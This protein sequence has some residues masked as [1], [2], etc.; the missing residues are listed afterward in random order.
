MTVAGSWIDSL[1]H[2]FPESWKFDT[3]PTPVLVAVYRSFSPEVAASTVAE[4][5]HILGT[6][7]LVGSGKFEVPTS[8]IRP[9]DY[10]GGTPTFSIDNRP[11]TI[12]G[13]FCLILTPCPGGLEGEGEDVA[14]GLLSAAASIVRVCLGHNSAYDHLSTF[15]VSPSGDWTVTSPAVRTPSTLFSPEMHE[16]KAALNNV[17]ALLETLDPLTASRLRQSL[18]WLAKA[19]TEER[20]EDAFLSLW[21]AIECLVMKTSD[22]RDISETLARYYGRT[23]EETKDWLS[24]GKVYG[25]R[26][27]IAHKGWM[28][29]IESDVTDYLE[30]IY[31]DLLFAVVGLPGRRRCEQAVSDGRLAELLTSLLR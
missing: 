30:C 24:I 22:I 7:V 2:T 4:A 12:D 17:G 3:E 29:G 21:I 18:R 27:R 11:D 9:Q 5:F 8:R 10:R 6:C 26:C 15:L 28:G 1:R 23:A 16:A 13:A 19:P 20:P 14:R 25:L 31:E